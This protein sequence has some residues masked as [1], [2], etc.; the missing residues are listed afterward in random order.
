M[1]TKVTEKLL[2]YMI[3][4]NHDQKLLDDHNAN[5]GAAAKA[6]G[7]SPGYVQMLKENRYD[8]LKTTLESH[9][10]AKVE[11]LVTFHSL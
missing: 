4:L 2:D 7:L 8:E 11:Q 1:A 6:Y 10:L 9:Q 5:P 3:A